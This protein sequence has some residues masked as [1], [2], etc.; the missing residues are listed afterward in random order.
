MCKP[1]HK[2]LLVFFALLP[3]LILLVYSAIDFLRG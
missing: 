1:S 2:A 3:T